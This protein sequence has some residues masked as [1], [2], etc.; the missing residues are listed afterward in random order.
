MRPKLTRH[1]GGH[2]LVLVYRTLGQRV[3]AIEMGVGNRSIAAIIGYGRQASYAFDLPYE[4]NQ[5][6]IPHEA[7]LTEKLQE[8]HLHVSIFDKLNIHTGTSATN[9]TNNLIEKNALLCLPYKTR[10]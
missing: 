1:Y 4:Y 6:Q 2:S 7:N 5:T 3:V 10:L 8:E 9:N